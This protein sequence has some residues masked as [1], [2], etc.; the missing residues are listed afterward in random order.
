MALLNLFRKSKEE[1]IA[2][3][4]AP[5]THLALED[6]SFYYLYGFSNDP[7]STSSN[8]EAFHKLYQLVIGRIGGVCIT[9]SFHPYFIINGKGVTAWMD[10]YLKVVVNKNKDEM[11]F[12]MKNERAVYTMN[13]AS[14]FNELK[15]WPDT[16]LTYEEN[17]ALSKFV[18]FIIPFLTLK[19]EQSTNWDMA[20]K[21]T[22]ITNGYATEYLEEVTSAI[23]F[24]MPAPAFVLGFDEFNGANPSALID[25]FIA[26]KPLLGIK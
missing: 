2:S 5:G 13:A 26:C 8:I 16:R 10:A 21:T 24:F 9:N 1:T 19:S 7:N 14:A 20:Q 12:N 15:V 6:F 25:K 17:P 11:F 18:P 3:P 4:I 22:K 23:R